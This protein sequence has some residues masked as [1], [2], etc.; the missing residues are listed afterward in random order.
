MSNYPSDLTDVQWEVVRKWI[1]PSRP[2]GVARQVSI[3]AVVNA[4]RY[5]RRSG[6]SWRLLPHDFPHWRTVYG[7]HRQWQ[8][9]GTWRRIEKIQRALRAHVS[10]DTLADVS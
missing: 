10:A 9:D 2:V 5:R 6:C 8:A 7:Y 4:V 3:R 1:P